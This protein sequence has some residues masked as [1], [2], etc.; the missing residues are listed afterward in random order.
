MQSSGGGEGRESNRVS[1]L[2]DN[3]VLRWT[4]YYRLCIYTIFSFTDKCL[5]VLTIIVYIFVVTSHH[6]FC[7]PFLLANN[8]EV[9]NLMWVWHKYMLT[10]TS[11]LHI[12]STI[13]IQYRQSNLVSFVKKCCSK[14]VDIVCTQNNFLS[15]PTK[16][17]MEISDTI[18][19][20]IIHQ[21]K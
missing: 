15:A 20:E 8:S 4:M 19:Y 3:I 7:F 12:E 11:T 1:D 14:I 17:N 2:C 5:H 18:I 9:A 6:T 16:I 10:F 13:S 21:P